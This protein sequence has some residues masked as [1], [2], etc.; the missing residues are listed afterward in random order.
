MNH[1]DEQKVKACLMLAGQL[2]TAARLV[3]LANT[4][5]LSDRIEKMEEALD[6]YDNEIMSLST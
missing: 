5:N 4:K 6:A 1:L 2:A 3:T